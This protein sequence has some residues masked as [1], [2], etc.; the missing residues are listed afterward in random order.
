MKTKKELQRYFNSLTKK[1]RE[2][3]KNRIKII[4]GDL[5]S[6]GFSLGMIEVFGK[7]LGRI[8]EKS[9]LPQ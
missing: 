4:F 8:A 9:Q 1:E 6:R 2:D 7:E 3:L 5:V